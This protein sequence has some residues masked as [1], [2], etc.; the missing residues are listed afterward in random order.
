M[1]YT[2]DLTAQ[3]KSILNHLTC[4]E[5]SPDFTVSPWISSTI[6]KQ[7]THELLSPHTFKIQAYFFVFLPF[8]FPYFWNIREFKMTFWSLLIFISW[9]FGVNSLC[10]I[11]IHRLPNFGVHELSFWFLHCITK[12]IQRWIV[13]IADEWDYVLVVKPYH[14]YFMSAQNNITCL[15]KT[16]SH[17]HVS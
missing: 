8:Y 2:P 13:L 1:I 15:P 6:F 14:I 5:F 12:I 7:Q 11:F 9:S 4:I 17:V 3:K 16:I 10:I